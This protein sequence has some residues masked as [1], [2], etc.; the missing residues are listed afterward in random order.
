MLEFIDP[1]ADTYYLTVRVLVLH[2]P[3]DGGALKRSVLAFTAA[4]PSVRSVVADG[5]EVERADLIDRVWED[6]ARYDT[7]AE[8]AKAASE[9]VGRPMNLQSELPVRWWGAS[10]GDA[11]VVAFAAHHVVFDAWSIGLML[12]SVGRGYVDPS[13]HRVVNDRPEP[14]ENLDPLAGW[15]GLLDR[16]YAAVRAIAAKAQEQRTA[17]A[18]HLRVEWPEFTSSVLRRAARGRRAT[19]YALG[20]TAVLGALQSLLHDDDVV[21]G[22]AAAGRSTADELDYVGYYSTTI[23]LGSLGQREPEARLQ[24]VVQQTRD[25]HRRPRIQWE[26]LLETYGAENLYPIKFGFQDLSDSRPTLELPGVVVDRWAPTSSSGR[27]RR[28]LD[29]LLG[30]GPGGLI[31]VFA[32]RKDAFDRQQIEHLANG[33]REQLRDLLAAG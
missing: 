9:R 3:V 18:D 7:V 5:R 4:N 27:A 16:P 19:P 17:P 21:L 20:V 26:P 15:E 33:T 13:V 31:G 12:S 11:Y 22:S 2:G 14:R 24:A 28:P 23:F 25:W 8:A 1:V 6:G 10:A 29:A 30:Y 32:Y